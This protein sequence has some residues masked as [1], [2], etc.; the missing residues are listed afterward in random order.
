MV[1]AL[2]KCKLS[3]C[4]KIL[5]FIKSNSDFEQL[6]GI[7]PLVLKNKNLKRYLQVKANVIDDVILRKNITTRFTKQYQIDTNKQE[8][9]RELSFLAVELSHFGE[10]IKGFLSLRRDFERTYM[11]GHTEKAIDIAEKIERMYGHSFWGISSIMVSL[12]DD[13][14]RMLARQRMLLEEC[15]DPLVKAFVKMSGYRFTKDITGKYFLTQFENILLQCDE[16]ESNTALASMFKRYM[17]VIIDPTKRMEHLELCELLMISTYLPLIDK[18][19][20]CEKIF[21]CLCSELIYDKDG[22]VDYV[23]NCVELLN[24]KL[25]APLWDNILLLL[26]KSSEVKIREEKLVAHKGLELF[27]TGQYN[28]CYLYCEDN[29]KQYSDN[30]A[31]INLMAKCADIDKSDA[32][33]YELANFIRKLYKKEKSEFVEVIKACDIYERFYNHFS[34]GLN[35]AIIIDTETNPVMRNEQILYINALIQ[36]K[37]MPSKLAFFMEKQQTIDFIRN[38]KAICGE[39]YFSD[40]QISTFPEATEEAM[41]YFSCDNISL[42]LMRN[43]RGIVCETDNFTNFIN[44]QKAKTVFDNAI[45]NSSI[46]LAIEI[47]VSAFFESQWMVRKM[48]ISKVNEKITRSIKK[49]LEFNLAYCIYAYLTRYQ[50]QKGE[51]ISETVIKSCKNILMQN[52]VDVPSSLVWPEDELEC[53]KMEYFLRHICTYEVL[54][55]LKRKVTLVQEVLSERVLILE[56]LIKY[57]QPQGR[58]EDIKNLI[59]EKNNVVTEINCLDI[60]SCINKG[61]I[62][63]RWIILSDEANEA[64]IYMYKKFIKDNHNTLNAFIEAFATVKKDYVQEINRILSINIRH[65]ILESELFRFFKKGGIA[66]EKNTSKKTNEAISEFN[67]RIYRLMDELL[68]YYIIASHKYDS[69]KK[70][71]LYVD[72]EILKKYFDNL[73]N[74]TM[75]EDIRDIYLKILNEELENSLPAWGNTVC[76]KINSEIKLYLTNLYEAVDKKTKNKVNKVMDLWSE[77]LKKLQQWFTVAHN[78]DT[79]YRLVAL[80]DVLQQEWEYLQIKSEVDDDIIVEGNVINFLY[81]IMREL[82]SNA[83]KCINLGC[84][85]ESFDTKITFSNVNDMLNIRV[86]NSVP[87]SLTSEQI[88]KDLEEINKIIVT[89]EKADSRI[90]NRKDIHEGRSGY[91]KIVKLLKRNYEERYILKPEFLETDYKF[92][93]TLQIEMEA[94]L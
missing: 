59:K 42:F 65:G 40:W 37:F 35:L 80:G 29:L 94:L 92:I 75:E 55:R 39:L 30:F 31:L 63:T 2:S 34:F 25:Q 74:I 44:A 9:I 13:N 68:E 24:E 5:G 17:Q 53:K 21:G 82:I 36:S 66:D 64:I 28:D 3:E 90:S 70:L 11:Q 41:S 12:S 33:Y 14:V 18:Y 61:K 7:M 38:Y 46:I 1:L 60:A 16:E 23:I 57:Y 20:L 27:C 50:L 84:N 62:N 19:C 26:K 4:E 49:E 85:D 47:Y 8:F 52:K 89:S 87:H 54:R 43:K 93:V 56:K 48:D 83:E 76:Q 71:V 69:D 88:K 72:E 77:E 91:K 32:P 79:H 81:T 67:N 22:N 51:V 58:V 6:K 15:K 78:Q 45:Q 10:E 86:I 73:K